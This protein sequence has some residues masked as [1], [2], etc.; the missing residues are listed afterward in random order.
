V[1]VRRIIENHQEFYKE[2]KETN[3]TEE[4]Y[5][6]VKK[7]EDEIVRK[8]EMKANKGKLDEINAQWNDLVS[9]SKGAGLPVSK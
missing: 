3:A 8:K 6:N 9:R 7:I 2:I 1:S 4:T 5:Y